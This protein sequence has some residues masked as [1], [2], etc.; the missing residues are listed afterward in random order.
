MTQTCNH[1]DTYQ[2][3]TDLVI[4]SLEKGDIIWHQS[5]NNF[6]LPKNVTTGK[7]YRGWNVF[8][9]NFHT[10]IRGYNTPFYLTFNQAR[11]FKGSIRKGEKG[12]RITYWATVEDNKGQNEHRNDSQ[13]MDSS[14]KAVKLIPAIHTVFNID[15][16][17]GIE[18]PKVQVLYRTA[19]EKIAASEDVVESMPCKPAIVHKGDSAYYAKQ[20]DRVTMPEMKL[21]HSDEAYY[22]TLFHELAHST[23]HSSRLNRKELQEYDGFGG[24]NYSKEELTAELTAAFLSA[25]TGIQQQTIANTTAYIKGWLK[26]LRND[27]KLVLNAAS[28]AQKVADFILGKAFE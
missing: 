23:G 18:F 12:T 21:F 17:E 5:W 22:T 25:I 24:E 11:Q 1:K 20:L 16:T 14:T 7:S 13:E 6:G 19:A 28:Q 9:L 15:Q 8:W 2:Q 26:A 3:I 10:M 27:K 4:D